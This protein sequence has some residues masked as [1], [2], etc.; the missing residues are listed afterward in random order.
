MVLVNIIQCLSATALR[1][2]RTPVHSTSEL[3]DRLGSLAPF[4]TSIEMDNIMIHA[5]LSIPDTNGVPVVVG[6][7]TDYTEEHQFLHIQ[8]IHRGNGRVE[9]IVLDFYVNDLFDTDLSPSMFCSCHNNHHLR[10]R[11]PD[12]EFPDTDLMQDMINSIGTVQALR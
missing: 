3:E 9:P 8:Y 11:F 7:A 12:V 1:L 4:V 6:I 2:E 5:E 10:D